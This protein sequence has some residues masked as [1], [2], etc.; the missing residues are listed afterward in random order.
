MSA[1][2]QT[3]FSHMS[4]AHAPAMDVQMAAQHAGMPR[5]F[6]P[7]LSAILKWVN[8]YIQTLTANGVL[9]VEL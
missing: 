6:R 2:A 7:I 1:T 5:S 8:G 4:D 3:I 9:V